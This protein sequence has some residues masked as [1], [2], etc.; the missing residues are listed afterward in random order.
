LRKAA[1]FDDVA[2]AHDQHGVGRGERAVDLVHLL[3]LVVVHV[4]LGQQD[5]HVHRASGRRPG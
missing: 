2:G 3:E 4:R 1:G 5:V